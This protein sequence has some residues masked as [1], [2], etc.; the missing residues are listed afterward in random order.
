VLA[1][2]LAGVE[3]APRLRLI[4]RSGEQDRNEQEACE[5]GHQE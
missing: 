4:A 5:K 2:S 1:V 3:A